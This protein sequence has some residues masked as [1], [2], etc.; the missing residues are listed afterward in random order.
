MLQ[1]STRPFTLEPTPPGITGV[2]A[3]TESHRNYKANIEEHTQFITVTE[4]LKKQLLVAV[5][6]HY[7]AILSDKTMG[8]AD[9]TC[10]TMLAHLQATYGKVS[11]ADLEANRATLN[12][13]WDPN[14]RIEDLWCSIKDAQD[15]ASDNDGDLIGDATA[16][17]ATLTVFE[18]AAVYHDQVVAW[19]NQDNTAATLEIPS[20]TTSPLR[21][22]NTTARPLR[23][24]PDTMELMLLPP[25]R[26]PLIRTPTSSC[27]RF[28]IATPMAS[29]K[30]LL[31]QV[32]AATKK[33]KAT[34]H[35]QP[36]RT[37]GCPCAAPNRA[38]DKEGS[39]WRHLA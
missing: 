36:K 9:V 6:N 4:E 2:V 27:S 1:S 15:F 29:P 8:Y 34:T 39:L 37:S 30:I 12:K 28:T 21:T 18:K 17:E 24:P 32:K 26:R 38:V 22:P 35:R 10:A 7:I 14:W 19:R 33:K 11:A 25:R 3:I 13:P 31:I 20:G 16:I 5:P 23:K